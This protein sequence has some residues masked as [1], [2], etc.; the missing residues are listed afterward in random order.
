M[1]LYQTVKL[2]ASLS[3]A[4][5]PA[6][7]GVEFLLGGRPGLGVVFLAIAALMLLFPE[8]VERK[9]GER[10]RAKLAGIPLVGR[11]FRE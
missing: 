10:L 9:L 7:V 8:Y 5:P 11:R 4:A 1:N 6:V 2:A 3:F